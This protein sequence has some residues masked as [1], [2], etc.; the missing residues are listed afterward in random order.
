MR[1]GFGPLLNPAATDR[2]CVRS[3]GWFDMY[4]TLSNLASL[5]GH[6]CFTCWPSLAQQLNS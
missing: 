6:A 2:L 1:V 5:D 3:I 4:M